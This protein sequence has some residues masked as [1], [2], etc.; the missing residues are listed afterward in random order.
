MLVIPAVPVT[1]TSVDIVANMLRY[2]TL[3]CKNN[4]QP[5]N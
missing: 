5:Y 1:W 4:S 3:H 2:V